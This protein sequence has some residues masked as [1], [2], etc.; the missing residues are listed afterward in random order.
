MK[1]KKLEQLKDAVIEAPLKFE[2][3]GVLFDFTAKV[4]LV[5]KDKIAELTSGS[6]SDIDIVKTLLVG[7]DKFE[8]E[9]QAVEF[10]QEVLNEL[11]QY[12]GSI[13]RI[14]VECINAQYR[15][16]EKN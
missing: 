7:W 4:K 12:D 8:D 5:S 2:F 16:Q 3:G 15:V 11:A 10:A 9:G 14:S 13:G 1:L 6:K